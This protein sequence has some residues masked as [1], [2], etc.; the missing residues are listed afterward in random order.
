MDCESC[1]ADT[2]EF[3]TEDQ[4]RGCGMRVCQSCCDVFGHLGDGLH[5]KGD[6]R[7]EV[8]SL[9]ARVAELE[10]DKAAEARD[11]EFSKMGVWTEVPGVMLHIT[12]AQFGIFLEFRSSDGSVVRYGIAEFRRSRVA[13][14]ISIDTAREATAQGDDAA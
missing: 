8:E 14:A 11:A 6:P 5:G 3:P 13:A 9:R 1:G 12:P 4:C 10:A 7:L 2:G